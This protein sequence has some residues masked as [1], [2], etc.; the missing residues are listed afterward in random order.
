MVKLEKIVLGIALTLMNGITVRAQQP[1]GTPQPSPE[2]LKLAAFLGT[3]QDEAEMMPGP[4]GRGGRM[5]L[6]ETCEWFTGRFSLVCHTETLRFMDHLKTLTV[7]TYDPEE[8][9]YRLYEF[10]SVGWSNVAKGTVDGN[11]WTFDGESKTGGRLIKSRSTIRLASP[12]SAVMKSEVSVDGGPWNLVMELKG[13][14]V[15]Q[16]LRDSNSCAHGSEGWLFE[17]FQAWFG[18]H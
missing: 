13:S 17:C 11:T 4:F 5:S 3:W 7:L 16:S 14:R 8:K 18:S 6:T 10:N 12:D 1:S 9:V 2:H 15:E